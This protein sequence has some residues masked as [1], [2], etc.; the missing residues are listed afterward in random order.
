M[1]G[2]REFEKARD[3][4]IREFASQIPGSFDFSEARKCCDWA[5][6]WLAEKLNAHEK[7]RLKAVLEIE[8][9]KKEIERLKEIEWMY[10][11]LCK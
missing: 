1:S 5:Y 2:A 8:G 3:A 9:L 4:W 10:N 11:D 6:K 7:S